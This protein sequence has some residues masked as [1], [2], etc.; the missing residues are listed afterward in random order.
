MY[1][2]YMFHY[3][4]NE[5]EALILGQY[6]Y[7]AYKLWNVANYERH[8]WK[9][10][11]GMPYP[12]KYDQCNRLKDN[13]FYRNL[14]SQTAQN[15]ISL[16]DESWK[17]FYALQKS[18]KV[19]NPHPPHYRQSAMQFVFVQNGFKVM[20]EDNSVIR[21]T[22]AKSVKKYL[23]A[24]HNLKVDYLYLK[25][26]QFK[27]LSNIKQVR[28][29]HLPNGEYRIGVVHEVQEAEPVSY[30]GRYLS[31]DLGIN[32]PMTCFDNANQ[33][34]FIV[35]K[36]YLSIDRWYRKEIAHYQSL[37]DIYNAKDNKHPKSTKRIQRLYRRKND[38]LRDYLHKMTRYVAD[39]CHNNDISAVIIGDIT[40]I[41][42]DKHWD[43]LNNQ[44]LHAWPFKKIKKM[45]EYKL[46]LYGIELISVKEPYTSQC[47]PTSISVCKAE[48]K[49]SNR[50]KRGLYKDGLQIY[51]ADAVG[52]Y[53]IMR[54]A[55]Q[56]Q[57][58]P[59]EQICNPKSL[60]NPTK[61][62]V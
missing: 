30:N 26:C 46:N 40:N 35:G 20:D 41:R 60:S 15:V 18:K 31:I 58:I 12:N 29:L 5:T 47:S 25:S 6:G 9:K 22:I 32:N 7:N 16:L 17:S 27:K 11:S 37:N 49:P 56:S 55:I 8:Q 14:P 21:F 43:A 2:T 23:L 62:A 3:K 34:S 44:K 53:N 33:K 51:N 54:K 24:E 28:F 59:L 19:E 10:D 1:L 50:R 57:I 13:F 38:S 42:K 36:E 52:A 39:Y 61:V 4:P 45:L 48:A